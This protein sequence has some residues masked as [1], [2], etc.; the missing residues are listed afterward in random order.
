MLN[1]AERWWFRRKLPVTL[2]GRPELILQRR[3]GRLRVLEIDE[4]ITSQRATG[5]NRDIVLDLCERARIDYFIVPEAMSR[6]SRVAI[7]EADWIRF[8]HELLTLGQ[9]EPLYLGVNARTRSGGLQRW[10]ELSVNAKIS[11]A[12]LSQRQ[13]EVF[14]I[15]GR[16]PDGPVFDR[17][18]ACWVERWDRDAHDALIA[19]SRNSR[20]ARIGLSYQGKATVTV[21]GRER[22]TLEVLTE[23]GI[24]DVDFPV[25]AVYMWVDGSD[26]AWQERKAAA[27]ARHGV[28]LDIHAT[29]EARFRDGGELLYSF[30]SLERYASWIRRVF[31]VTD[32][33]VPSWLVQDHPSLTVV[34][35]RELFG[36]A[37]A[38]PCFNSHAIGGR[39]HHISGLAEHYICVNDDVFFGRSV[40][41]STFFHSNGVSKFFMSRSTLG[42]SDPGTA[43]AFEEARRNAAELIRRDFGRTPANVFFHTP[44]PQRRSTLL[45]LEQRYADAFIRTWQS[46]FRSST[47]FDING[48]LHHYYGYLTGRAAPGAITY[49]YFDLADEGSWRRMNRRIRRHDMDTFCVNDNPAATAEQQARAADWLADYFPGASAF[50]A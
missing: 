45:E 10:L 13:L 39:L 26:P 28:A 18:C 6:A 22:Q 31:L 40:W 21:G 49:D 50:E 29:A 24:F 33:Q 37:G 27:L 3:R 14:K 35:H 15:R 16:R 25:D 17:A 2:L 38:L 19:P 43:P 41:P 1:R 30:R 44:I 42:Y 48:W 46:Q 36:T 9:R 47:D 32:Q 12:A 11:F 34:D 8:V 7:D 5:L 4:A 23:R 20:A